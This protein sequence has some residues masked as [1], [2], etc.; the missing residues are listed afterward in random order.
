MYCKQ[1]Y[2]LLENSLLILLL[3]TH[4][5]KHTH[6]HTHIHKH[7]HTHTQKHMYRHANFTRKHN[8]TQHCVIFTIMGSI[9]GKT[10]LFLDPDVVNGI[11]VTESLNKVFQDNHNKDPTLTWQY[12]GSSTGFFRN[13]PGTR[14]Q[15]Q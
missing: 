15:F 11:Y 1:L 10:G 9:L 12:F 5:H 7:I 14:V 4:N 2:T 6:T 13:Y 8:Y 3:H